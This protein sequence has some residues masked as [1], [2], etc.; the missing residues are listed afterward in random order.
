MRKRWHANSKSRL[1][2]H[3]SATKWSRPRSASTTILPPP[4][5]SYPTTSPLCFPISTLLCISSSG[6]PTDH[7]GPTEVKVRVGMW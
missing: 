5:L 1:S 7:A 2:L 3:A 4:S 6:H